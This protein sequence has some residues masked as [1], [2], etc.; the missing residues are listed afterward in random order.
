MDLL[1]KGRK[2]IITGG[3][4]GIGKATA[5]RLALEGCD[6]AICARSEG[7]L[8]EAA[9]ELQAET[10]Q[11][12]LPFVCDT[13]DPAAINR[14]VQQA[15]DGL[16]GIE[17]VVNSAARVGGTPGTIETVSAAD[18]M[19]DFEEKVIGYLRC[20]QAAIP[21]LKQAGWG[22]IIN[23]SGAAGRSPG[24][25]VSGGARNIA[26]VNLTKSMANALGQYGI[27]VNAIYPGQTITEVSMARY[28]EQAEKNGKTV[29]ELMQA[30]TERTLL[31]HLVSAEDIANVIVFLCSPLAVSI[32]GEV[33]TVN[34]GASADVHN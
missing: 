28:R 32:T 21:H 34:G 9:A 10:G 3:S 12:I 23:I 6:V 17:I 8:Q 25:M 24:P 1:L 20:S 29:E 11:T 2:A 22:R 7:P 5:R 31:K 27:T 33:I 30:D 19:R 13:M 18:V 4:R 15:A 14:F 26:T 16:G